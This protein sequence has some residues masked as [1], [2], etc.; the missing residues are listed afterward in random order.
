MT[1]SLASILYCALLALNEG[2]FFLSL[3][4]YLKNTSKNGSNSI[5]I[6][7]MILQASYREIVCLCRTFLLDYF[8]LLKKLLPFSVADP[9][10]KCRSRFHFLKESDNKNMSGSGSKTRIRNTADFLKPDVKFWLLE[11]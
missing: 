7:T 5:C 4:Y 11:L 10:K 8:T 1:G 3:T 6:K 2:L 9:D